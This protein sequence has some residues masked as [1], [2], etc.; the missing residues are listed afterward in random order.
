MPPASLAEA[1]QGALEKRGL[2]ALVS[3]AC[4][5]LGAAELFVLLYDL[6][7][8]FGLSKRSR[9]LAAICGSQRFCPPTIHALRH[10]SAQVQ[11]KTA[12]KVAASL[13][14]KGLSN[15]ARLP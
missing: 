3:W 9:C 15:S 10:A 11:A 8:D 14:Y 7:R 4:N 6:R 5:S 12:A 1:V 13:P 2:D